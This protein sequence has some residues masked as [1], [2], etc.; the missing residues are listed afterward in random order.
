VNGD[1][2]PDITVDGLA[3]TSDVIDVG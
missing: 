3:L 2:I 1:D